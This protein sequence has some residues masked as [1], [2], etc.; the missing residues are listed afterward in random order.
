MKKTEVDYPKFVRR[1]KPYGAICTHCLAIL[2]GDSEKEVVEKLKK[3]K[4]GV[5]GNSLYCYK[6]FEILSW[7]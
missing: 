6:C 5:I 2:Q 7:E 4:W 3:K 1:Q